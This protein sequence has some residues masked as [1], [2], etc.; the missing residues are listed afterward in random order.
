MSSVAALLAAM[1][2]RNAAHHDEI[3]LRR[4]YAVLSAAD[5]VLLNVAVYASESKWEGEGATQTLPEAAQ[6]S[7]EATQTSLEASRNRASKWRWPGLF[8][9]RFA[10]N[11]ATP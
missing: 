3:F 2:W 7:P 11:H 1:D 6:T 9:I 5:I 10:R 4:D 8:G